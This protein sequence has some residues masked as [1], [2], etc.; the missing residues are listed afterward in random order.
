MSN[1]IIDIDRLASIILIRHHEFQRLSNQLKFPERCL[2][3]QF[4]SFLGDKIRQNLLTRLIRWVECPLDFYVSH[5]LIKV[6]RK[7]KVAYLMPHFGWANNHVL[8]AFL[9]PTST[10]V[11]PFSLDRRRVNDLFGVEFRQKFL[12]FAK[13]EDCQVGVVK[14]LNERIVKIF[15]LP[16][17]KSASGLTQREHNIAVIL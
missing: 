16:L 17:R 5:V 7:I 9:K 6:H 1:N 12:I 15:S 10:R 2:W 11:L 3:N 13:L 4:L 8:F 14:S